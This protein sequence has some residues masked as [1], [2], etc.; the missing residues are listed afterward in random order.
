MNKVQWDVVWS[1]LRTMLVAGGPVA[2]LLIAL[3]FPPV[4][5][6]TYLG[7]GLAVVAIASV[8]VP[9]ILGAFSQ[10]DS[11][12]VTKV[13]AMPAPVAIEALKQV[14]DE[15]KIAIVEKIPDV[16]TVVVKDIA[17]GAVAQLAASDA[18]PNVVTETQNEK[19]A[20]NG[21]KVP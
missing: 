15:T 11:H 19:D 20:K 4:Q 6:S 21:T 3:G 1:V 16:A 5:V 14:P 13:A 12:A 7:V 18:H 17:N 9:G 8:A 2:T 10:T